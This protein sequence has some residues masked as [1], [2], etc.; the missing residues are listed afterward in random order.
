[1]AMREQVVSDLGELVGGEDDRRA[2]RADVADDV[3]DADLGLDVDADRRLVEEQEV[4]LVEKADGRVEAALHAAGEILDRLL[5]PAGE[6]D[7]LEELRGP[8][9]QIGPRH[10]VEPA[11]EEQV[12]HG[13]ELVVE[14]H[15]LGHDAQAVLQA[16]VGEEVA[17][18]EGHRPGEVAERSGQ[19][20]D[21]RRLARAVRTEQAQDLAL[22]EVQGEP[23]EGQDVAVGLGQVLDLEHVSRPLSPGVSR[24]GT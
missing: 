6:L 16:P 3:E 24:G 7:E 5:G 13:V 21:E 2:G 20:R 23:V 1:M 18:V 17:A 4:G 15:V 22:L 9:L 8:A 14:G 11:P 12:V 10:V 19:D